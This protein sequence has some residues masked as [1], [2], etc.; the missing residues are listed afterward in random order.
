MFR[1][2]KKRQEILTKTA[3]IHR[4]NIQKRL[5]QRLEAAKAKG[6]DDLVRLL[7]AE[8]RYFN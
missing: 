3:G 4:E 7:E 2:N 1:S 6:N 8:A 5:Q